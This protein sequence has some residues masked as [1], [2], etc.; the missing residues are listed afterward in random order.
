VLLPQAL[1]LPQAVRI[2][3]L[4][5]RS[6]SLNQQNAVWVSVVVLIKVLY[7]AD[8]TTRKR[9]CSEDACADVGFKAIDV[10]LLGCRTAVHKVQFHP[11]SQMLGMSSHVKKD[12]FRMVHLPSCSVFNNWPTSGTPLNYVS[13]FSFSP[14]GGYAAIGNDKGKVLLY[15]VSHYPA[16]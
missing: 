2:E 1:L 5:V 15:R 4:H 10:W 6:I 11:K 8:D 13:C 7:F 9:I 16:V 14:G 12:A 3:T